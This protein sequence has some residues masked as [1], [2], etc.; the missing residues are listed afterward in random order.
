MNPHGFPSRM[1]VTETCC[2][3]HEL[4]LL[5]FLPGWQA[6]RAARRFDHFHFGFISVSFYSSVSGKATLVSG[7]RSRD[8]TAFGGH[9]VEQLCKELSGA[10]YHY[11]GKD[12][13]M[14]GITGELTLDVLYTACDVFRVIFAVV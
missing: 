10:G 9:K 13:M 7:G 12:F 5:T 6:H 14:S 11:A 8:G 2:C 1:T 4:V 3:N